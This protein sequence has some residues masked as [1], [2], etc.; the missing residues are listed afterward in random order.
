M[1]AWHVAK[2]YL[3]VEIKIKKEQNN[4]CF[5]CFTM[6]PLSS[7]ESPVS[8]HR[9]QPL[10]PPTVVDRRPLSPLTAAPLWSFFCRP[11]FSYCGLTATIVYCCFKIC[12]PHL[13]HFVPFGWSIFYLDD[14]LNCQHNNIIENKSNFEHMQNL[15]F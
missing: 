10:S 3:R 1:D 8:F 11:S 12:C 14:S 6:L 15:Q 13:R 2:R 4:I 5:I 7:H 9:P